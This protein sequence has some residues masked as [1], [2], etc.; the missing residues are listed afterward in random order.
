M[1]KSK[2]IKVNYEGQFQSITEL[3]ESK[4]WNIDIKEV[5][6]GT[7]YMKIPEDI[8]EEVYF[9]KNLTFNENTN[10]KF[11]D[12]IPITQN[13]FE[14]AQSLAHS[15]ISDEKKNEKKEETKPQ[16]SNLGNDKQTKMYNDFIRSITGEEKNDK[17]DLNNANKA[18]NQNLPEVSLEDI[19]KKIS[20]EFKDPFDLFFNQNYLIC[21]FI[22][23]SIAMIFLNL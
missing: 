23:A 12:F 21:F 9:F 7:V 8:E 5:E 10:T 20:E 13:E 17:K 15:I 14:S 4:E 3:I 1:S 11:F 18:N 16:N 2:Y 6:E 19:K 22:F